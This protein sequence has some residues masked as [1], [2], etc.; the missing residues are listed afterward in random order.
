ML[1]EKEIEGVSSET[2][3]TVN[4]NFIQVFPSWF[5]SH[6]T[7]SPESHWQIALWKETHTFP[8]PSLPW[9]SMGKTI[10]DST[11]Y[12]ESKVF[13]DDLSNSNHL[14]NAC[15]LRDR[16]EEKRQRTKNDKL[17]SIKVT[18]NRWRCGPNLI[19]E[20]WCYCKELSWPGF[21][22]ISIV[23][24]V[25]VRNSSRVSGGISTS[26]FLVCD[27]E[28]VSQ[29]CEGDKYP[30]IG[31]AQADRSQYVYFIY[32][33]Y[34][35]H[36]LVIPRQDL[37]RTAGSFLCVTVLTSWGISSRGGSSRVQQVIVSVLPRVD[38]TLQFSMTSDSPRL[39][40]R[41]VS[42]VQTVSSTVNMSLQI[43]E[44]DKTRMKMQD[45]M[46]MPAICDT[47]IFHFCKFYRIYWCS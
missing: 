7:L 24:V 19:E 47:V 10:H 28:K 36:Y 8:L 39:L 34:H 35:G 40:C 22:I 38:L 29:I 26:R 21:W 25:F 37:Q 13:V 12:R 20:S 6:W 33:S 44:A 1:E 18:W 2:V 4:W 31:V 46:Q 17:P 32:V 14:V 30:T 43:S 3:E 9:V 11:R 41:I 42:P 27:K 15:G 16:S 5:S 23:S 45:W